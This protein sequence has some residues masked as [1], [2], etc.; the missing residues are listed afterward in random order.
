MTSINKITF[1]A[2]GSPYSEQFDDIYFDTESGFQQSEH[3]FIKENNIEESLLN[4]KNEFTIAETGFGT[5]LNFLLTLKLYTKLAQSYSLAPLHFISTEKFP[6]TKAQLIKALKSLTSL[7]DESAQL[8]AS[9]PESP[10]QKIES[11]FCNN[12]IKL[13]LFLDDSTQAFKAL[14]LSRKSQGLVNAWYLDGFSPAR[15]P[16]MWQAELFEQMARLSKPQASMSTFTIAGF[17]RRGLE[18]VG[19]RLEKKNYLG[20]KNE[21]LTG[22]YQQNKL[23]GKGYQLRPLITKPQHVSII[24]GGIASACAAYLLTQKGIK[25]TIYCKDIKVAQGASSNAIGALFPLIHQQVDDISLFYQKAF[26]YALNLYNSLTKQGYNFSHDWCGLLEIS[27]KDALVKRQKAFEQIQAWPKDLIHSIDNHQA[28]QYANISLEHGGLFMPKSGWIA[29]QELVEQLFSAAKATKRLRIETSTTVENIAQ[30]AD[31]SWLL[32]TNKG[33]FNA[34]VLIF[35]GGAESIKLSTINQLPLTSVRGQIT[36]MKTNDN[37]KKLNTV[38]CHKGYLTPQH[39][40]LHC[41]GA[42]FDKNSFDI[43]PRDLDDQ[44]NINML[45]QCLPDVTNNIASW[46]QSDILT[47]KARLR[48]MTPDHLPMVGAMPDIKAH[49][50]DY[51]HLAKDKNWRFY[52]AAPCVKNLYLL[53][54][55]G[56]RG[57]CTAP[58]LAQILAADLAG[59]PYPVDNEMLFNLSPNR[60]VIRD[61]IKRKIAV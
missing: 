3:V 21:I 16:E 58:L 32:H 19:F 12:Q 29:P 23:N 14:K 55:L 52:Q 34:S 30:K 28:S 11:S 9:Y 61:L 6:L 50:A 27:Y 13:T 5:G 51:G 41:I 46:Q 39:K 45:E 24:G 49:Q 59:T 35:C 20:N 10:Q 53:T 7:A 48:C 2:D 36:S 22:K 60:F 47:R 43:A 18:K 4:A 40:G 1:R 57:L 17:I 38:I 37:I 8:I 15:N 26:G 44:Y 25:V 54:G 56:A 42:T 33:D 31:E